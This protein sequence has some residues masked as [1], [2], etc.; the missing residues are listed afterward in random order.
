MPF[1]KNVIFAFGQTNR[2]ILGLLLFIY[3]FIYLFYHAND[4][5]LLSEFKAETSRD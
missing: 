4:R 1:A 2:I 3:S 5:L